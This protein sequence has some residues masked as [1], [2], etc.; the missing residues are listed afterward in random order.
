VGYLALASAIAAQY[1][2]VIVSSQV[3]SLTLA[4]TLLF[5]SQ[6]ASRDPLPR[7]Y[8]LWTRICTLAAVAT[9][10]GTPLTAGFVGRWFLYQS[11]WKTGLAPLL[12]LSLVANSLLLAPLLKMFL[13][14]A[15]QG[16]R[17]GRASPLLLAGMSGL[18]IPLVILGLHPPLIG[19]LFSLQGTFLSLPAL[20]GM[21]S[22]TEPSFSLAM[23]AGILLSLTLGYLMFRRGET[24]VVRAGTSLQT[25]Q[26]VAEMEWLYR[27]LDW[28][29]QRVAVILE[30]LGAF[31]EER[32]SL[33]WILLFALLVALLLLSS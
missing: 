26:L 8:H 3:I 29:V 2:A 10:V 16:D 19:R 11:L 30:Q 12:L 17:H 9:L 13:E 1:A 28:M 18:A 7:P 27:A 24:I 4:L 5:L 25:L 33:S 14:R 15:P 23:I 20:L 22:S 31:F 32:R 6:V 21:S